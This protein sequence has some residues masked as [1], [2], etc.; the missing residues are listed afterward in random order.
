MN[1]MISTGVAALVS[2][3]CISAIQSTGITEAEVYRAALP[4]RQASPGGPLRH[5]LIASIYDPAPLWR[6]NDE[7]TRQHAPYLDPVQR[8]TYARPETVAAFLQAILRPGRLPPQLG[9]LE[10]FRLVEESELPGQFDG[11]SAFQHRTGLGVGAFSVSHIGFDRSRTQALVYVAYRCGGLCASGRFV[12]LERRNAEW[13]V[14]KVD[15]Y[16]ES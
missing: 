10:Q 13:Q 4:G 5:A 14:V 3:A 7:I 12:L 2:L 1:P 8:L 15:L 11:W 9:T 16:I 6:G